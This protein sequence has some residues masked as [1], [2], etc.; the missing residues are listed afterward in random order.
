MFERGVMPGPVLSPSFSMYRQ[1]IKNIKKLRTQTAG[2][3]SVPEKVL[4]IF[5][6]LWIVTTTLVI[7]ITLSK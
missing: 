3:Q 5:K 4:S 7:P 2:R 1:C 6:Y